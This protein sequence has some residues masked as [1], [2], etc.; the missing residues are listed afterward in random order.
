MWYLDS[1]CSNHMTGNKNWFTKLDESLK[2]VIK[3]VDGKHITS[4]G[5]RD[6][7]IVRKVGRK[8]NI[9]DVLYVPSMASNMISVDNMTFQLMAPLV[10]NMT[11]KV[12]INPVYHKCIALTAEEDDNWLWHHT[13][14]YLNFRS[15]GMLNQKKMVYDLS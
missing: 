3:F 7:F 5:K 15:L 13:Y 6:I 1:G 12:E 9:I 11:S 2:K 8:S 14:G 10:D 4:G